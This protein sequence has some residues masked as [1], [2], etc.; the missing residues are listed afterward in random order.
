VFAGATFPNNSVATDDTAEDEKQYAAFADI[1][2]RLIPSLKA[3]AGLR[4]SYAPTIFNDFQGGYFSIGVPPVSRRAKFYA[5]TPKFSLTYDASP[6]MTLYASASQ[7]YRIGG[8]E[9]Y[10]SPSLCAQ[11][12][13]NLGLSSAPRNFNS[14][15]LWSYEAGLKGRFFDGTLSINLD[16]YFVKWS[17][18]QQTISLPICG[19]TITTNVGDAQSYGPELEVNYKPVPDLTLGLSTEYTHDALTKI[20][21][22]SGA[23]VGDHILDVPEWMATLRFEYSRPIMDDIRGFA[24]TDYD[25]TGPSNGAFSPTNPD[26]SRPIYSVLNASVGVNLRRIEVSVFAKNL[27]DDRKI[28][29]RPA[30]LFEPEAYT[31]R[32]LTVGLN[33]KSQF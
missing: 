31:V 6:E 8:S 14:D 9:I 17:N 21:S 11:D 19:Y 15:S 23:A 13:A 1:S 20:T 7:G 2:Y 16:A 25:W 32:P 4:Y 24:R 30:L 28:I 5:T 22:E 12:L 29:Q 10:I 3:T 26:Y 27:L 18:I 33:V